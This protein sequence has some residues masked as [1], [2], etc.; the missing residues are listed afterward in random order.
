MRNWLRVFFVGG[1]T[2]YRALFRWLNPWVYIPVMLVYPLFQILFFAYLGR[3][4]SL[5]SDSFFL[6]GNAVSVTAVACLFGM[7]QVIGN[8]RWFQTLPALMSS[9]ASRPALFLGRSLPTM[10]NAIFVSAF[11][12]AVGAL[13]LDVEIPTSA[14]PGLALAILATSF[15]CTGLGLCFGAFGLRGRNVFVFANLVDGLILV[16]CGV[17]VPIEELPTWVQTISRG[18]PLTHGIEAARDAVAGA[19][20]AT[21]GHLLLV[22]AAIGVVYLIAGIVLL[23]VFELE[24]RRTASLETF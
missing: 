13:M 20:L 7:G 5:E 21:I 1:M 10:L 18:L 22:E 6:I 14:I 4:V 12:L 23:H 9:P 16:V 3:G 24:S 15:S 17:N 2:S 11:S 19:D 8:E